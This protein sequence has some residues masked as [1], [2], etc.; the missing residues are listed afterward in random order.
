MP[1]LVA[2]LQTKKARSEM[3]GFFAIWRMRRGR[4][5]CP[6]WSRRSKQEKPDQK[7][8]GFLLSGICEEGEPRAQAGRVV[9]NKESPIRNGRALAIWHM[10]RGRTSC[11]SWS[12]R[13]KQKKPDQKWSGFLLSGTC[14]EGEPRAQAGR[15]APNKESPIRNGRVFCYPAHAKR[16][17]LVPKLVASF[18]TKKAR[19]EMVGFFVIRHMRRGR[20]S[21]PSWSRRSKQEKPDQK[22]SGFLLSGIYYLIWLSAHCN[23]TA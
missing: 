21:C 11:P 4:T 9:P 13:S 12:R 8:S 20:T 10:R 14:D 22:W 16:A 15:V 5:S 2:S 19:S 7:W 1:K 3:V 18:Q 23:F 6:S 17:N